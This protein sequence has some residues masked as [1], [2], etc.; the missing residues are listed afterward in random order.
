MI[1]IQK[2]PKP[3]ILQRKETEWRDKILAKLQAGQPLTKTDKSRYSHRDIKLA[4][5]HETSGKCCY[6]ESKIRHITYGDIEH[7]SP[8]SENPELWVEWLNLT[9]A[10][11]ICN[12]NKGTLNVNAANFVDP[13]LIDPER[14]FWFAG[15]MIVPMP[16]DTGAMISEQRLQLNRTEL[17]DRRIV[18][19]KAL[20]KH[21]HLIA[22]AGDD[23]LKRLLIE[24]LER[25]A[26]DDQ[27]YAALARGF[28][29]IALG[30]V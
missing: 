13:Y 6:C 10:C 15:P 16:G 3:D 8:K 19:F 28:L 21:L 12:T 17:V 29:R 9:L 23:E 25:E 24:D 26:E 27:E 4:L 14:K 20:T 2:G 1:R 30:M 18:K 11:D 22:R 7:I 5:V